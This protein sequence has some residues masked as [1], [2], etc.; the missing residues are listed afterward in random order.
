VAR[1]R[2][3]D[4]SYV[5]ETPLLRG[6]IQAG[7]E[8]LRRCRYEEGRTETDEECYWGAINAMGLDCDHPVQWR[9]TLPFPT[10]PPRW[11]GMIEADSL[12]EY[13]CASCGRFLPDLN[14]PGCS[15]K[16][17]D[18]TCKWI[19]HKPIPDEGAQCVICGRDT[20]FV[21]LGAR[22]GSDGEPDGWDGYWR[23]SPPRKDR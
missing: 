7:Y 23:H 6:F 13:E 22:Y 8:F 21:V 14:C 3:L 9:K 18:C 2:T 20:H 16:P 4:G 10:R 17:R 15:F 12:E 5:E 1:L 11:D 19:G